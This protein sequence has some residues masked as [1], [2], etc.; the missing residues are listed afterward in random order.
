M[1]YNRQTIYSPGIMLR[2]A[3]LSWLVTIATLV[4][5][6]TVIIPQQKKM[7]R[8]NLESKAHG[9]AVSLRDVAA[10]AAVN[11][12]Y[13][14]VVDH[15]HD[16]LQDDKS[17]AYLI[18]TRDDGFS[19]FISRE[20]W[21]SE[22]NA[23][24]QW[25]PQ[26]RDA[27]SVIEYVPLVQSEVFNYSQPF[28]YSG[29]SWGWI[30]IG[31]SLESY[32]RDV[33]ALYRHIAILSV[34]CFAMSLL[35][36]VFYAKHLVRPILKLRE[37][38][39][40]VAG[41]NLAA[42][43]VVDRRDELGNLAESVNSMTEALLQRDRI[44]Q[45]VH[46]AAQRFL[47]S[48]EW[49]DVILEVLSE[50]GQAVMP[51]R[52]HVYEN[53]LDQ[54]HMR[55]AELRFEWL[56][57][58]VKP[59]KGTLRSKFQWEKAGYGWFAESYLQQETISV[60]VASLSAAQQ[61]WLVQDRV[62]SYLGIPIW[63]ENQWWGVLSFDICQSQRKWTDAEKDSLRAAAQMLGNA[64]TRQRIQDTLRKA[65]ETAEAASYAKSQFLANMSHEIR[66]PI[67]GVIGMLQLLRRTELDKRQTRYCTNAVSAA[68][69]LLKVI[70]DVLDFSKIEAGKMELEEQPFSVTTVVETVVRLFASSAEQKGIELAF[71]IDES[72]PVQL[73]GDSNRLR[74]ILV[75][76]IGNA[77]KFTKVGEVVVTASVRETTSLTTTL[78]F[79]VT[80]TG[81]G[82]APEKQALIF[83]SFAQA[84]N[85]MARNYG[86][87]G[88]G[89]TI[90]RQLCELMGGNI[91]VKSELGQGATFEFD[92]RFKNTLEAD[93][94]RP[95]DRLDLSRIRVLVV[96]DSTVTRE[97]C[98]ELIT[99]W[100]GEVDCATDAKRGLEK[101]QAAARAGRPYHVG[102]IDWKMRGIDGLMLARQIKKDPEL[103]SIGLVLLSSFAHPNTTEE[104]L[105]AGFV[106]S[107]PKPASKSDLY[108]AI[109]LAANGSVDKSARESSDI[110]QERLET[111]DSPVGTV[112]L[113]EDNEI[114]CEVGAEILAELG[115]PYR[116]ARNGLEAVAAH[117]QGQIDL[118][119]MD[120]QMP[121]LDGYEATRQIRTL[122]QKTSGRRIPIVALT[123]HAAKEDRD[124]CLAAGMDDYL[125]KPIAPDALARMLKKWLPAGSAST[126]MGAAL[127]SAKLSAEPV[128]Y[129]T[130]LRRCLN[131]PE[132]AERLIQKLIVQA[133]QDLLELNQA[134]EEKKPAGLATAA[135]RL[136]GAAATV[137]AEGLRQIA[138]AIEQAGRRENFTEAAAGV[139]QIKKELV[140]LTAFGEGKRI[141][142]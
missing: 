82:I 122:E 53:S 34:V 8:D 27:F 9:L 57:P 67:N 92:A 70:G 102:V 11:E 106:A 93:L 31:L 12:D 116:W 51:S 123:A 35:A 108:D 71:R 26:K 96:D 41:G 63:V 120:C 38:V 18:L 13:S 141:N 98:R 23:D 86:G 74:Q 104:V 19:L 136:K 33:S 139:E 30:H 3:L 87:S 46:F 78:Q 110:P 72:I 48:P 59:V 58:N 81:C 20:S 39:G 2:T 88:L 91:R 37:I 7:F 55:W 100:R 21:H 68:E 25:R 64:I 95:G 129:D 111:D 56:A 50:I 54:D 132:L 76:L 22:N 66:T 115:Y 113:A 89:L 17:L 29:L 128:E 119:L 52:I 142:K 77:M 109:I 117:Q 60:D 6:I 127:L 79:S 49:K 84:D 73:L 10:G 61:N 62:K 16:M 131:K 97:I 130:L 138:L 5:F 28:D 90:S 43:A 121:E 105:A 140:R 32:N 42:R 112:L 44:L 15:C 99:A 137:S 80:D 101:I 36:S 69:T 47:N 133:G 75:N 103:K 45:S 118:I 135:H 24:P 65:K 94:P 4:L 83:E 126:W 107:L 85:S 40:K 114:N 125:S 134:I 1:K 124:R 14:E